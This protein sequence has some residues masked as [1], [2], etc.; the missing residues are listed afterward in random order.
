M[1]DGRQSRAKL[2]LVIPSSWLSFLQLRFT[3]A[4]SSEGQSESITTLYATVELPKRHLR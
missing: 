1:I 3:S 2:H 4:A